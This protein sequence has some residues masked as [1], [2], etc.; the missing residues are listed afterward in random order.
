MGL[1]AEERKGGGM[2]S[3]RQEGREADSS[4]E[5]VTLYDVLCPGR[6]TSGECTHMHTCTHHEASN[7][8]SVGR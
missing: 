3:A 1:G 7:L 4:Q 6:A 8:Y 5:S 2:G